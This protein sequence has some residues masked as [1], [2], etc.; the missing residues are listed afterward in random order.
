MSNHVTKC[1]MM[2]VAAYPRQEFPLPSQQLYVKMLADIEPALLEAAIL[3][4]ISKKTFLPAISEVREAA[5]LLVEQSAGRLDAV[6]AWGDVCKQIVRVGRYGT[7]DVDEMTRAAIDAV[8]GWREL[9]ASE[10][11]VAD[12]ARF[13]QAY[14]R[15][16]NKERGGA[17]QLPGVKQLVSKMAGKLLEGGEK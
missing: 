1:V 15:L 3:D 9:C 11:Q 10:N 12:R 16:V 7:P 2:L 17:V 6:S 4:I 13:V 14:D 8:G 5:A